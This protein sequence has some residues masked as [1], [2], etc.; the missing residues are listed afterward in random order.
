MIYLTGYFV[1][2]CVV[3][4]ALDWLICTR[5]AAY[6]TTYEYGYRPGKLRSILLAGMV[7]FLLYLFA[8]NNPS[9]PWLPGLGIAALA[10]VIY[11]ILAARDVERNLIPADVAPKRYADV[12][13]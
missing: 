7:A 13:Y 1:I 11:G 9:H 10:L 4:V 5:L 12:D 3:A 8:T 2:G 6:R